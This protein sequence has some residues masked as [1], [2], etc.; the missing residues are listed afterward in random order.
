MIN[1]GKIKK[2]TRN[3]KFEWGHSDFSNKNF[4]PSTTT[5]IISKNYNKRKSIIDKLTCTEEPCEILNLNGLDIDNLAKELRGYKD[6]INKRLNN[7]ENDKKYI[8]C[9][10]D[11]DL[12]L[13]KDYSTQIKD[14]K[15]SINYINDYGKRVNIFLL[16]GCNEMT[17]RFID[18][19]DNILLLPPYNI[20]Y[21]IYIFNNSTYNIINN[22]D[23][24]G[25]FQT[26]NGIKIDQAENEPAIIKNG[27]NIYLW[28]EK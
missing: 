10:D 20:Q 2:G 6:L 12:L 9:L 3:L 21:L 28:F 25:Q 8:L 1:L 24:I 11:Y 23:P 16:L 22:I 15:E 19:V 14:I 13:Y 17:E 5:L 18:S 27:N 26:A 7:Q 4:I